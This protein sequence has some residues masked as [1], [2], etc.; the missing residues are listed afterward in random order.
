MSLCSIVLFIALIA[1]GVDRLVKTF[2]N[3]KLSEGFYSKPLT[4]GA[5]TL[6]LD[7][8]NIFLNLLKLFEK[9]K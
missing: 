4:I 5:L 3:D 1:Y 2:K 9:R 8:I 6:Y 7:F